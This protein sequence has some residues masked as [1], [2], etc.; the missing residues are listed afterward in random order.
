MNPKHTSLTSSIAA[1]SHDIRLDELGWVIGVVSGTA[2]RD[3]VVPVG[4]ARSESRAMR[5]HG[6]P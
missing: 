4:T 2:Y 3:L 6:A 5:P 1:E